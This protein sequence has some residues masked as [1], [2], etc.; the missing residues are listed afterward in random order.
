[1]NEP[2]DELKARPKLLNLVIEPNLMLVYP[3]PIYFCKQ[4]KN[5]K[6]ARR[7]KKGLDLAIEDG[8]FDKLFYDHPAIKKYFRI[9]LRQK[10]YIPNSQ[11]SVN[12]TDAHF[13]QKVLV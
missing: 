10:N 8:S 13:R 9:Q 2:W 6:L 7:I 12:T 4:K 1:M 5:A 11:S 3:A